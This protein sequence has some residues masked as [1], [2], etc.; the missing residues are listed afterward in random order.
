MKIKR[1]S[2]E[3]F[4]NIEKE[5]IEFLPGSNLLFGDTALGKTNIIEAIYIFSRGKSFRAKEDKELIKFGE[6]G[7]NLKI[8]YESSIGEEKLEYILFEKEKLRRKNGYRINK[9]KEMM[10]SFSAVLFSPD[11]LSLVKESPEE[12]R[13][14]LNV[15][16]SSS[17]ISYIDIYSNYKKALENRNHILK[18]ASQNRFYDENELLSW[19]SYIAEYASEIYLMRIKYTKMLNEYSYPVINDI[20]SGK[21]NIKIYYESDIKK[22][23]E[24][25]KKVKEEYEKIFKENLDKEKRAGVTLYGPHRDD[26]II[27]INGK[28]AR[29]FASQGQQRTIV[30]AL[31]IAEGEIIKK[32]KGEYPVFLFDDVLSELDEKRRKYILEGKEEKQIIIS[33]CEANDNMFFADRIIK[34]EN[35]KYEILK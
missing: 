27:E 35:G 31:K 22:E 21:E 8:E 18:E 17:F 1:F 25:K 34:V 24:D 26:L 15:G 10:E 33:S 11:D 4:R 19:S 28:S 6:K 30:L 16:I 29:N 7:F 32:I 9:I 2:C 20:S 3:N 13:N 23:I 5:N 12:R 14:F